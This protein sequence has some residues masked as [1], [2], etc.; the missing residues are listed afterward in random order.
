MRLSRLIYLCL[1]LSAIFAM[2]AVQAACPSPSIIPAAVQDSFR[3]AL[4]QAALRSEPLPEVVY[5]VSKALYQAQSGPYVFQVSA[6][7]ALSFVGQAEPDW[8]QLSEQQQQQIRQQTLAQLD[9]QQLIIF[10]P[11]G[12]VKHQIT[13]FTDV[14]C[15]Y[16]IEIHRELEWLLDEGVRVRY[17]ALPRLGIDSIGYYQMQA[18]WCSSDPQRSLQQAFDGQR[19]KLHQ[20][21]HNPVEAQTALAEA[22]RLPGTPVLLFDDGSLALGYHN[23]LDILAYL[24]QGTSLDAGDYSLRPG[25]FA[26]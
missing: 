22:L 15:P 24:K 10:E 11:A 14:T 7:E 13:I 3:T 6:A 5:Q 26:P 25:A 12:E 19:V 17:A 20:C 18:I 8:S 4:H 16:S 9:E 21:E 23:A 1:S 2:H